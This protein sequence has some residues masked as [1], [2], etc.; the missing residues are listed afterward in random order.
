M[1]ERVWWGKKEIVK[2]RV[3]ENYIPVC[4]PPAKIGF[5]GNCAE[6]SSTREGGNLREY[7]KKRV[8]GYVLKYCPIIIEKK[9]ERPKVSTRKALTILTVRILHNRMYDG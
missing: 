2:V 8:I 6:R 1:N 3:T 9:N 4:P 7:H 5:I